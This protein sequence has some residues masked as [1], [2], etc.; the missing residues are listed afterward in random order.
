MAG[1]KKKGENLVVA[2]EIEGKI[3]LIRG[4]KVMLDSD[5]AEI[6]QVETRVLNQAVKRNL[7][8][9]PEDFMFQLSDEEFD[10]LTMRSQS[11]IASKRNIRFR[12]YAFTEHG[13][14]MLASVLKA[15]QQ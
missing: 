13:A 4:Q 7:N 5:L 8:R 12:P 1:K 14:V 11:V 2:D 9:F 15:K 3:Y 10:N 6:Y